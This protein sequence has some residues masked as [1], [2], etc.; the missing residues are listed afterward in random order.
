MKDLEAFATSELSEEGVVIPL[1]DVEG[2]KTEHWIKIR[3]TDSTPFKKSQS[4]FR[5][6]IVALTEL[7]DSDKDIDTTFKIE[8]ET[9]ILLSSLV[10]DWSFKN[11]DGSPYPCSVKNIKEVLEKAPV[12]A[13]EIDEA[14]AKRKNF[15]KRNLTKSETSQEKNLSSTKSQKIAKSRKLTT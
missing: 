4:R 13:Q 14:S 9:R 10:V 7:E 11:D 15:T 12:L 1:R 3:G 6:K 8:E 5:R 2:K